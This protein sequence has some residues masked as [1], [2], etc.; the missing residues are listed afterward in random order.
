MSFFISLLVSF[1]LS[2]K[3][4]TNKKLLVIENNSGDQIVT[5]RYIIALILTLGL[6]C[7]FPNELKLNL[8][9]WILM[10]LIW[11][12]DFLWSYLTQKY[13][14][15]HPNSSF[16]NFL[17]SFI[18]IAY[19]P[20]GVIFLWEYF[21]FWDF[22]WLSCIL[23]ALLYFTKFKE[24]NFYSPVLACIVIGRLFNI[25]LIGKFIAAGW[26]FLDLLIFIYIFVLWTYFLKYYFKKYEIKKLNTYNYI[27]AIFFSFWSIGSFFLYEIFQSYE[28]KLFLLSTFLFNVI[29][30]KIFYQEDFF[31]KKI[32]LSFVIIFWLII[33]QIY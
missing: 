6:Y 2:L 25:Y 23:L 10:I 31:Y 22:V 27:D 18:P 4:I 14:K 1:F 9:L 24:L 13:T 11:I 16:Q 17:W 3:W 5:F 26:Y 30:F 29:L 28:V 8:E 12:F 19:I 7:F 32:L 15:L 21:S 33:L 20:I